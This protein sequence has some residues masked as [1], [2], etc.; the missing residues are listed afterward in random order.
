MQRTWQVM[1]KGATCHCCLVAGQLLPAHNMRQR[2]D[3]GSI[4]ALEVCLL[5]LSTDASA[6]CSQ[7]F[8]CLPAAVL[9]GPKFRIAQNDTHHQVPITRR[10]CCSLVPV[11][12]PFVSKLL[13]L[14]LNDQRVFLVTGA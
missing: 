11:H 1:F 13:D 12:Y 8:S 6:E 4:N 2:G 5:L 14:S 9:R 10:T 3:E 7:F